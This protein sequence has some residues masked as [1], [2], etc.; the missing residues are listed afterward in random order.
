MASIN[1]KQLLQKLKGD[2]TLTEPYKNELDE[3]HAKA[4]A[5]YNGGPYGNEVKGK[6]TVVSRDIKK[7]ASH[8]HAAIIDPFVSDDE[9]V[10]AIP[11]TY[12][13]KKAAEQAEL[14]LNY[15]FCRDF[16]RYQ[17]ISNSFKILQREGTVVAKVGW[18][19][20]EEEREVEVPD[21][22]PVK[23][24]NEMELQQ[25]MQM[26][27]EQAEEMQAM[28]AAGQQPYVKAQVGTKLETQ[29][30]V[31]KNRPTA[32]L[33]RN[34]M[35]WVDPTCEQNIENAQF[36]AYKFKS[37]ISLLREDGRYK[38]LDKIKLK[39]STRDMDQDPY[40]TTNKDFMFSDEA[41]QELD[42]VEYWGNYDLNGDGIA[43]PIVC[44]WVNDVIIRLEDNPYPDGK[45]PFVSCAFDAEPFSMYG[46]PNGD[47]ISTDQKIRTGIKRAILDTL[48]SSTNG[49]K[50]N[51]KGALDPVNLKK[52]REGK[53]FEF[54]GTPGDLWEGHFAEIPNSIMNFDV[55]VQQDI[56]QMTGIRPAGVSGTLGTS[57]TAAR[58][59]LDA[60]AKRE[61][62]ISRNYKDTFLIPI[63]RKWLAMDMEFMDES[64]IVR[65]T[66][67][68]FVEVRRDDLD[69]NIDIGMTVSTPEAD[70]ERSQELSFMLQTMG[71][72]LPFEMTQMLLVEQAKLK[73][74]PLLAKKIEAYQPQPDP[75]AQEK[76]Q[77]ENEKL[78]A[79]IA[80]KYS[81]AEEN[82]EA[83]IMSKKAKATLEQAKAREIHSKADM[84]DLDYV[85]KSTG[86]DQQEA[87]E[88]ENVKARNDIIKSNAGQ[89]Y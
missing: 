10:N 60:T 88:Q 77:L 73:K 28:I 74:M 66:N 87:I 6:A 21:I 42:V 7:A 11:I 85:R 26:Y 36:V 83:D 54:N 70:N 62:D 5:E 39:S 58:G 34:S 71:Q 23:I 12:E 46:E 76:A 79:E 4:I 49:Q 80:E 81:R 27:P 37:N 61:M 22:Q 18:E 3:K 47:I 41:R 52:F 13:D 56:E 19:I 69:G 24:N 67:E 44:V 59:M 64:Q 38:N 9:I 78:K 53:Y 25:A 31:V 51:K 68:E 50:G 57:A 45:V 29:T 86:V 65:I 8:Q 33:C 89:Q 32:E 82:R 14:L 84:N 40:A 43:E 63:L 48:D 55:T 15:Q 35:L 72:S 2:L 17:F 30:V 75:I 16:P 1:K 20:V